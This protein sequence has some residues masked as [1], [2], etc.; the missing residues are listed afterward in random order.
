MTA[1][2]VVV[3]AVV[4]VVVV[5]VVVA[6]VVVVVAPCASAARRVLTDQYKPNVQNPLRVVE[7]GRE[8]SFILTNTNK[9]KHNKTSIIS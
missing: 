7:L 3:V 9:S 6:V 4:A 1:V 8:Q 5:V 2:V